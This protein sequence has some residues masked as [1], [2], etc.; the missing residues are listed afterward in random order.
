[1]SKKLHEIDTLIADLN[2]A[3]EA[4]YQ[5]LVEVFRYISVRESEQPDITRRSAH[6]FCRF[7]R[8]INGYLSENSEDRGFSLAISLRHEEMHDICRELVTSIIDG[9]VKLPLFD[10]FSQALQGLSEAITAWQRHLLQLR[11]GYDALTG[12]PLRR[13]LDESFGRHIPEEDGDHIYVLIMDVD[14]FKRVNDTWGHLAGDSVLR[15]LALKLR[16]STRSYEPSYR[17]GG[18]EFITVL[19]ARNDRDA[20]RAGLRINEAIASHRIRL[21]NEHLSITVTSG[22]TRAHQGETLHRVLER[23]DSAMY[24]GKQSGRNRCM[25]VDQSLNVSQVRC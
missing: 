11:S 20:C 24:R 25:F 14:H 9:D 22:L 6:N 4:H 19:K 15:A 21:G 2:G 8:W 18:E 16:E 13:I 5:W 1:M 17:F 12:L 7:G 10:A 23:A 3:V